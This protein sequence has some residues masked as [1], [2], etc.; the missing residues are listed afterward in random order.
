MPHSKNKVEWCLKK[1]KKEIKEGKL[2]RGLREI[3]PDK[4]IMSAHIQKAEH[5]LKAVSRFK[6]IGY[7]DWSASAAFYS[8]YH[9]LLAIANKFGFESRNQ[10]C[11]FAL[12]YHLIEEGK[13]PLDKRLIEGIRALDPEKAHEKPTVIEVREVEQYG[14]AT[15]LENETY[16]RLLNTAKTILDKTK[17]IIEE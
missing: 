17:T 3:T 2:H 14:V 9:S 11:T 5:N 8:I 7:S 12:I 6:E 1:A 4:K 16:N 10:E 15:I 13:I